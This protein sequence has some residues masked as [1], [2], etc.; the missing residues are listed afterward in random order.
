MRVCVRERESVCV[1][2]E[3]DPRVEIW[4]SHREAMVPLVAGSV[5]TLV[6]SRRRLRREG[7]APAP[8]LLP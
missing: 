3:P 5:I 2:P 7:V 8:K 6:T 4:P 1:L